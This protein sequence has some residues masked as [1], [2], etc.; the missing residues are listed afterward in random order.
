MRTIG[1]LPHEGKPEALAAAAVLVE[2]L[3]RAGLAA[4]MDR[5]SA[6]R[7][8]RPDLAAADGPFARGLDLAIALG[9]DGAFLRAARLV[10]PE[11]TPL[12]GVNFGHLGFLAEVEAHE[13]EK[14]VERFLAGDYRLEERLMVSAATGVHSPIVG[15]ND[16][17]VARGG[18]HSRLISLAIELG[19]VTVTEYP[20]DGL[21]VATPTG[22]TAYSLSAGG[23]I[24][25]P[26]LPALVLTPV[27]AHALHARPL[28]IGAENK[29]TVRV[30]SAHDEV[31]LIADGRET[32]RLKPGETVRFCRAEANTRLVRFSGTGFYDVLK[33]R[34]KQGKL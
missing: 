26:E 28:V 14:A 29:I 18:C 7:I 31:V 12:F 4:R 24:L 1:L 9:G 17:V 20:A 21:I 8:G 30:T 34:F 23:P 16:V 10:Y 19:G 13:M 2:S 33:E 32:L 25:H 11:G 5:G 22:S 15:L 27:C 6:A 3:T